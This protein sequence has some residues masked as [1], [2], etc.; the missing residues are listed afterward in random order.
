MLKNAALLLLALVPFSQA[1]ENYTQTAMQT[2]EFAPGGSIE[3]HMLAGDLRVVPVD[4]PRISIH[5]TMH[6]NHANFIAKVK[7]DFNVNGS[8]AVVRLEAPRDGDIDVELRVPAQA[9]LYLRVFAGAITV[10]QIEGNKNVETRAGDIQ[11]QLP[12]HPNYA[13]VDASTLAGVVSAR[14][15]KPKAGL[16]IL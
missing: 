4:E 10:G 6:S 12:E 8:K 7:P 13:W 9:D 3:F 16:E 5:Y 11:I 14:S 15:A 1:S 2:W